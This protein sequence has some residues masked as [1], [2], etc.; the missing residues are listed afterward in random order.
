MSSSLH[1]LPIYRPKPNPTAPGFSQEIGWALEILF[2]VA[3]FFVWLLGKSPAWKSAVD[4]ISIDF[5]ALILEA[6][7]FMLI[8]SLAGGLIEIFVPSRLIDRFF[9][10]KPVRAVFLAGIFGLFIPVCE[11]AI[12]PVIRRLLGKG[13]PFSAAITFLL[14]GPIVN[15]IVFWS[16]AVAYSY[17]WQIV[18]ARIGC[19]YGIAVTVGMAVGML[20]KNGGGLRADIVSSETIGCACC[21]ETVQ[22]GL[23]ARLTHALGHA[24]ADF[25]AVGRYLVIGAF[26]SAILRNSL[27]LATF[28][29]LSG[30][31]WLAILIMMVMAVV[32]NLCSEAD[33]F[34]A[35][36]FRGLLPDIAQLA[37]MV[38]GPMFDIKL[39]LMYFGVFSKRAIFYLCLLIPA[40]V[41]MA[42]ILLDLSA[43]VQVRI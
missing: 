26:I 13:V 33:A 36:S 21:H 25:I 3:A 11:C 5:L 32:L 28:T 7:P 31:P 19:G 10:Q 34:I 39:L 6:L 37:F 4:N 8:G 16:T 17:N 12:I 18:I 42:M 24:S 1:E 41:F 20:F 30:S 27:P 9:G 22:T 40:I 23:L 38:L 35:A 2:L 15:P 29:E 14:A 43:V